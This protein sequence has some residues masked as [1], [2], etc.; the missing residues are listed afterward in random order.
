M[1][2]VVSGMNDQGLVVT[3]NAAKS[4]IP[5]SAKTPT[6]ILARQILQYASTIEEAYEMAGQFETFVAESFLVSSAK[7]KRLWSLKNHRTVLPFMTRGE[8]R[9][10]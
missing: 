7:D 2:G 9:L 6:S 1:I 10:S 5:K 4:G 8:K 3:L